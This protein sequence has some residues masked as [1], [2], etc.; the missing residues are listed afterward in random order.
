MVSRRCAGRWDADHTRYAYTHSSVFGVGDLIQLL[1][2]QN[3]LVIKVH[4]KDARQRRILKRELQHLP[5]A[6]ACLEE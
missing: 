3:P 6:P 2:H 4:Q 5:Q 1:A